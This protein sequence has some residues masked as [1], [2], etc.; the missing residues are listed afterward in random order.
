MATVLV[1]GVVGA[2][3]STLAG[4]LS[5]RGLLAVDSDEVLARWVDGDERRVEYPAEP[6]SVCYLH[7]IPHAVDAGPGRPGERLAPASARCSFWAPHAVSSLPQGQGLYGFH[8]DTGKQVWQYPIRSGSGSWSAFFADDH[9]FASWPGKFLGAE[10]VATPIP[11]RPTRPQW[12]P[13]NPQH[14]SPHHYQHTNYHPPKRH[15][16]GARDERRARLSAVMR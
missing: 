6:A 9:F 10:G 5:R 4:E 1:L 11:P 15:P 13:I 3:K 8:A 16:P 14:P 7:K 12:L 2:G